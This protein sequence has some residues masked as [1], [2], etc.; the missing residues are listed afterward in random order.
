M[1]HRT[2]LMEVK[3]PSDQLTVLIFSIALT[4]LGF[5]VVQCDV[6]GESS[7]LQLPSA[8]EFSLSVLMPAWTRVHDATLRFVFFS[9]IP[10][11]LTITSTMTAM[12]AVTEHVHRDKGDEDQ[13]P[14]PVCRKPCHDF[15]PSGL[16]SRQR[17]MGTSGSLHR[18]P[19]RGFD[20]G[21]Q[22]KSSGI[23]RH[24]GGI[25]AVFRIIF[26]W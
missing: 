2:K 11:S 12:T 9:F 26:S 20:P 21:R 4:P 16:S 3:I 23:P 25:T 6:T 5:A 7:F 15:S 24:G 14:E 22:T 17:P 19:G 10:A 8:T 18:R 13:H 1:T